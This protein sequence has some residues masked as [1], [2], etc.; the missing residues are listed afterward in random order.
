MTSAPVSAAAYRRMSFPGPDREFVHGELIERAMPNKLHASIQAALCVFFGQLWRMG[1]LAIYTEMRL[2]LGDNLYRIPDFCIY[3]SAPE[4]DIPSTPPLLAVEIASPDDK[5]SETLRKLEE[6]RR[7][8]VE[9]I[10]HID[11]EAKRLY[12]FD[13]DGL[14]PVEQLNLPTYNFTLSLADLDL[15]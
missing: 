7:F 12:R 13:S 5:F 9:H 11:P 2:Q 3:K 14:H 8:G 4:G 15:A 10:W 1:R 6:Y